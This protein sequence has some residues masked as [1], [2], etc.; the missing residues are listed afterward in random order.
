[1]QTDLAKQIERDQLNKVNEKLKDYDETSDL[2]LRV[3]LLDEAAKILLSE[4]FRI[5]PE[6]ILDPTQADEI[7][8]AYDAS[9]STL[10]FQSENK[11]RHFPID[12][13]VHGL[14]RVRQKMW[15]W[16]QVA[17]L[18]GAFGKSEPT[19]HPLQLP[20][21]END[22][23]LALEYPAEMNL[24]GGDHLLYTGHFASAF[25]KTKPVC[26]LLLDEWTEV[27]PADTWELRPCISLESF[28]RRS[29]KRFLTVYGW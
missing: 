1:M 5:V 9:S 13:R 21:K 27:I 6:F 4:E 22:N 29:S 25:D 14:A 23:W 24:E 16:E 17:I 26:G 19:L 12:F 15:H 3:Q 18:T 20:F 8:N 7:K 28:Q 2:R 11:K 10:K